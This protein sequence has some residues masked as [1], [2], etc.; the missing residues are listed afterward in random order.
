VRDVPDAV[1]D[2]SIVRTIIA[3]GQCLNLTI[4]AEGVETEGQRDFL[5]KHGCCAYQGYYFSPAL[6][7]EKFEAF[8]DQM[9]RTKSQNAA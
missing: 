4:I 6:Q 8:V 1:T 3:L 7:F 2:A 9:H 5:E